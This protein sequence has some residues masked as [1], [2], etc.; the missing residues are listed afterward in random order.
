MSVKLTMYCRFKYWKT[1]LYLGIFLH[2]VITYILRNKVVKIGKTRLFQRNVGQI[3]SF[4]SGL[5]L[6]ANMTSTLN[7]FLLAL[8][9]CS[10]NSFIT[11]RSIKYRNTPHLNSFL[12][13]FLGGG[14]KNEGNEGQNGDEQLIEKD[15]IE[16]LFNFFFGDVQ[17]S[18][19][20]LAR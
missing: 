15:P 16:K 9:I 2:I 20:G 14:D 1:V 11:I 5:N 12:D 10:T 13:D 18:P 4:S 19:Q 6:R 3:S 17:E 8:T 7:F